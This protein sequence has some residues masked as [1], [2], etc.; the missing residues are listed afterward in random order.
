MSDPALRPAPGPSPAAAAALAALASGA[1]VAL[2]SP[3]AWHPSYRVILLGILVLFILLRFRTGPFLFVV[4]AVVL[5]YWRS[6][7]WRFRLSWDPAVL[8]DKENLL[9]AV[10]VAVFLDASHRLIF[11]TNGYDPHERGFEPEGRATREF[12]A[13]GRILL[14]A[15]AAA[16]LGLAAAA[17][18]GKFGHEVAR[19]VRNPPLQIA[20]LILGTLA[21]LGLLAFAVLGIA[22]TFS[23]T[24]LEA[25]AFL[26]RS[27]WASLLRER[28]FL[29]AIVRRAERRAE[30]RALKRR[31]RSGRL[32]P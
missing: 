7:G 12:P 32:A 4:V 15:A 30:K 14:G 31:L 29:S 19:Q 23:M 5:P 11:L 28:W 20:T 25:R 27:L 24:P 9:L 8:L 3:F 2:V 22:R 13:T 26:H 6:R 16:A 10:L 1:A 17:L 21:G 18:Y